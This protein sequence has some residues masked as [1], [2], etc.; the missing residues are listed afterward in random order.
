V[1][2]VDLTGLLAVRGRFTHL[3]DTAFSC[4]ANAGLTILLATP[5]VHAVLEGA[6]RLLDADLFAIGRLLA[7]FAEAMVQEFMFSSQTIL[8]ASTLCATSNPYPFGP[9]MAEGLAAGRL[10]A[11]LP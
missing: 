7:F 9:L 8:L 6:F 2:G 3:P 1:V 4:F 10:L 11:L 5:T